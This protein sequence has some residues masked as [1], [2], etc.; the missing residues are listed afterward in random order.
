MGSVTT[1][2]QDPLRDRGAAERLI[3][4]GRFD[5]ARQILEKLEQDVPQDRQVQFLLAL[6]DRQDRNY[7]RAIRRF[8]R[9][10]VDE[11]KA[12]RVRLELGRTFFEAGDYV[13]AERQFRYARAGKIPLSVA[14]NIDRYLGAIRQRKTFSVNLLLSVSSD[15]NLNAGPATD[16]ITLYGLPFQLSQ[17][18]RATSGIGVV[19]D[20]QA[21]WAP[22]IAP[23]TK[24]LVGGVVHRAQ[25]GHSEF[26]DTTLLLYAGPRINLKSWE[27]N[28]RG[29]AARRWYGE[30]P[31]T[32]QLGG[33]F[34][35]TYFIDARLGVTGT[36]NVNYT[37]YVRNPLQSGMAG[38]V[39]LSAF[40]AP[41][42]ASFI[43]GTVQFGRQ[44]AKIGGYANRSSLAGIQYVTD[45]KGGF[46]VGV[47]P[48]VTRIAYDEP[49]AAFGI[50]RR[51]TQF[52]GQLSLLNRRLDFFGLTP[53]LV[54]T[55][56][57]NDS[58]IPLYSF[59]RSKFELAITSSF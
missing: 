56:M 6:L 55:Y 52:S 40:Y 11:P 16:A 1:A 17:N 53:K 22:R 10:L 43:R 27:L 50:T 8:R 31:Y 30:R 21:E 46:T 18:A 42:P 5:E 41:T 49:L 3:A 7:D 29:S 13:S 32:D 51:D 14:Q 54:Y 26:N 45:L 19:G 35:A 2:A 33:G 25:Y 47:M 44:D 59:R 20:I 28:L 23:K 58:S 38:S 24:L 15:S 4:A 12:E 48:S 9:I 36:L 57:R 34:D 39:A 37:D